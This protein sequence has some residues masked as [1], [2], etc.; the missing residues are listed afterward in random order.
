MHNND[1]ILFIVGLPLFYVLGTYAASLAG[2]RQLGKH[3][4]S[5]RKE[6]EGISF[7]PTT[8]AIK[9]AVYN[10]L[11]RVLISDQ[12]ICISQIIPI[13]P[14]HPAITIPWNSIKE[15]RRKAGPLGKKP[16]VIVGVDNRNIVINVTDEVF[17]VV[18]QIYKSVK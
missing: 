1:I 16:Q 18:E 10:R 5:N 4:E 11:V 6:E 3:F 7:S 9:F 13:L 15:I 12:G 2:W 17:E 8:V 14:F